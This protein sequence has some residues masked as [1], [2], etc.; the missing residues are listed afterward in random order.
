MVGQIDKPE[1]DQSNQSGPAVFEKLKDP[2]W[3]WSAYKPSASRP[4]NL[5]QAGHLYRR[6]AFGA[7]WGQLQQAVA[8]GPDRAIDKLLRP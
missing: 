5:A 7:D 6:A 2:G 3:A 1:R 8:D 4:W